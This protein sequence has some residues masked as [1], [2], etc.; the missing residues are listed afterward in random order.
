[1]LLLFGLAHTCSEVGEETVILGSK[2]GESTFLDDLSILD[3]SEAR[4]SLHSSQSMS[5][6]N[7]GAVLHD[8]IEGLLYEALRLFVKGTRSFVEKQDLR[9]AD[10]GSSDRDS[11]L[12]ATR[13]LATAVTSEDAVAFMQ[14]R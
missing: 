13:K 9:V 7:R 1:M 5:D 6:D 2:I 8:A 3:D 14:L 12:L 4:A 10:D 11:L